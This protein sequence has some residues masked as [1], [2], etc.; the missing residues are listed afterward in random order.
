LD[1]SVLLA[2]RNRGAL[3][4]DTLS[5]LTRLAASGLTWEVIAVD[6]GSTDDTGAVLAEMSSRLPLVALH[7]PRPGK[8]TALNRALELARGELLVFTDDDVLADPDWLVEHTRAAQK[9]PAATIFAG[10]ISPRFP[11]DTPERVRQHEPIRTLLCNFALPQEEGFTDTLPLGPNFSVRASAMK[12]LRY[13]EGI[14]PRQGRDFAMGSET[15]LLKRL[16][17]RGDRIVYV[18]SARVEHVVQ[19]HQTEIEWLLGRSFRLG[20]GLTRMGFVYA[21]PATRILGVPS[22]MWREFARTQ[23][24]YTLSRYFAWPRDFDIA[25]EYQ[26]LRGAIHEQRLMASEQRERGE[27]RSAT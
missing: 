16:R 1:V 17:D 24:R 3:L 10:A 13:E 23:M 22:Y 7:E 19:P 9:W 21:E 14:G 6:N 26:F 15:E 18:P 12:G 2:T 8:N 20:R 11:A 4:R 5:T 27:G 25:S